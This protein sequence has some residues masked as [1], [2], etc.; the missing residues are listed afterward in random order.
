MLRIFC[1][2]CQQTITKRDGYNLCGRQHRFCPPGQGDFTSRF[3]FAF[4]VTFTSA[5][6]PISLCFLFHAQRCLYA[7]WGRNYCSLPHHVSEFMGQ[8]FLACSL[9]GLIYSLAR[10]CVALVAGGAVPHPH[11]PKVCEEIRAETPVGRDPY[12]G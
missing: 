1:P 8:H 7:V 3:P 11:C 9:S 12:M 4:R 5:Q 2:Y 10:G 6:A